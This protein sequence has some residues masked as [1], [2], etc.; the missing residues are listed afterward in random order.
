MPLNFEW[1]GVMPAFG[2]NTI[3]IVHVMVTSTCIK[4]C[5]TCVLKTGLMFFFHFCCIWSFCCSTLHSVHRKKQKE[6]RIPINCKEPNAARED[7]NF[8][9]T[10]KNSG[11]SVPL[12]CC[13]WP[14]TIG[15]YKLLSGHH[16]T[17]ESR[18]FHERMPR[19]VTQWM[20]LE[21]ARFAPARNARERST[22][23]L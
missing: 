16:R 9:Y 19:L 2:C 10:A 13:F 15:V 8:Y 17:I 21:I 23:E 4:H 1:L 3:P 12:C 11:W 20:Q 18:S 22:G 5:R 7:C 14:P 6:G